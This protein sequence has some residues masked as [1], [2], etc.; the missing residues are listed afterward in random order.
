MRKPL[1]YLGRRCG[2]E[3]GVLDGEGGSAAKELAG[4]GV[5]RLLRCAKGEYI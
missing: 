2:A 3:G 4:V 1:G 5:V